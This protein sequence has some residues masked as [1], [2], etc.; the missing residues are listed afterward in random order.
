[1]R[2]PK[3]GRKYT[4]SHKDSEYD[5]IDYNSIFAL[6]L[7]LF[8]ITLTALLYNILNS[9]FGYLIIETKIDPATL[10]A[11]LECICNTASQSF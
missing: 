9:T 8:F 6:G 1:M 2:L 10:T 7:L 11:G 5:S 3:K 4:Y